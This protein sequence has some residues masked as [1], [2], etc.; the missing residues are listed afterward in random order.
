MGNGM[1]AQDGSGTASTPVRQLPGMGRQVFEDACPH[2]GLPDDPR[3][4]YTFVSET[5]RCHRAARPRPIPPDVQANLCLAATFER[6]PV[7]QGTA[8]GFGD[9]PRRAVPLVPVVAGVLALVLVIAGSFFV[10]GLRDRDDPSA[11]DEF[12]AGT[13]VTT[14]AGRADSAG[15]STA[16]VAPSRAA[17][18]PSP[19]VITATATP[20][21]LPFVAP[22]PAPSPSPTA[23]SPTTPTPAPRPTTHLVQ[24]GDSISAIAAFYGLN[25]VSLSELNDIPW[26]ATIFPGQ[27]LRLQ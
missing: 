24:A 12:A 27:V 22:S 14:T 11:G 18:A 21:P 5:H 15:P 16:S 17:A 1:A 13:V 7:Y 6:C 4:R 2:L 10:I 3:S 25:P 8:E 9:A 26:N 19:A 20:A 23:A